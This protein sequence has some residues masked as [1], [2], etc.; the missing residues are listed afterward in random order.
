VNRSSTRNLTHNDVIAR[1]RAD[2][3]RFQAE[4]SAAVRATGS[5]CTG[6]TD[7]DGHSHYQNG[8]CDDELPY[9]QGGPA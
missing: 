2:D 3:R 9:S 1:Q 4:L 8:T 7:I 5:G 6:V